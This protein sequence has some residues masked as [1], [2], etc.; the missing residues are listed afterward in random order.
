[1]QCIAE[2]LTEAYFEDKSL[3][4][5]HQKYLD[6]LHW[7]KN[8]DNKKAT[9]VPAKSCTQNKG[10]S[11]GNG[12]PVNTPHEFY[13]YD[14][15]YSETFEIERIEHAVAASIEAIFVL[16]GK[17]DLLVRQDPILF[18]KLEETIVSYCNLILGQ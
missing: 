4:H 15:L 18:D 12:N 9:F 2:Q 13:E 1:M 5:K 10:V 17:S 14:D 7:Q 6:R 8:L 16:L 11:D 3:R